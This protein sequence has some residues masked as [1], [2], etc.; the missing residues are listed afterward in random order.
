VEAYAKR[1]EGLPDV[2]DL[3]TKE[4]LPLSRAAVQQLSLSQ[5][6]RTYKGVSIPVNAEWKTEF[7]RY[8]ILSIAR[9]PETQGS[10]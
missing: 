1:V 3:F 5:A 10:G 9:Q 2:Y 8:E 4:G 7:G 6:L